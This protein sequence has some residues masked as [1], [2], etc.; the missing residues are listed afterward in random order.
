MATKI[1]LYLIHFDQKYQHA[2]HYLGSAEDLDARLAQ[3]ASGRGARL[4]QV[5]GQA[6]I[7]WQVARTWP[8]A[9][10]ADESRL[11]KSHHRARLCPLCNPR[12]ERRGKLSV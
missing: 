11:K 9:R 8:G 10:R 1:T 2:G 5:I 4:L 3:H 6:G 7:G 12:A